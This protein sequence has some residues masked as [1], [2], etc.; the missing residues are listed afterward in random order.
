MARE[1][2]SVKIK[3][4]STQKN[5]FEVTN[6]GKYPIRRVILSKQ[7]EIN[8]RSRYNASFQPV[9]SPQAKRALRLKRP[10]ITEILKT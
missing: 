7:W 5:V 9:T 8:K 3:L 1:A 4:A 2:I 10:F 6:I